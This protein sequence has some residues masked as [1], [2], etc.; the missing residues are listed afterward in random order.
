MEINYKCS[1]DSSN[2]GHGSQPIL[3]T[4]NSGKVIYKGNGLSIEYIEIKLPATYLNGNIYQKE[5]LVLSRELKAGI[6]F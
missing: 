1:V 2:E 4:K 5:G 3:L 6:G